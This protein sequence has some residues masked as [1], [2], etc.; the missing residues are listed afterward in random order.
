MFQDDLLPIDNWLT[1]FDPKLLLVLSLFILH[2]LINVTVAIRLPGVLPLVEEA[3]PL[4]GPYLK[5]TFHEI[6]VG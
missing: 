1:F 4:N 6:Q 5:Q 3:L 2:L